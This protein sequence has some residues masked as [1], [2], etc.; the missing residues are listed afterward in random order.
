MR[1]A[2]TLTDKELSRLNDLSDAALGRIFLLQNW[3]SSSGTLG[4]IPA[5]E[6]RAVS[7]IFEETW[8]ALDEVRAL[9]KLDGKEGGDNA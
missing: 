4:A 2:L 6:A 1:S 5:A 7:A 9:L 8:T 3:C